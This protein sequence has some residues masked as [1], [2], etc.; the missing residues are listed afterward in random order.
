MRLLALDPST[1]CTGY[2][3]LAHVG[4]GTA[5]LDAGRLLPAKLAKPPLERM[6]D[7][8]DEISAIFRE[9]EPITAAVIETAPGSP[10]LRR[11]RGHT[12]LLTYATGVGMMLREVQVRLGRGATFNVSAGTWARKSKAHRQRVV[13][14]SFP[15]YDAAADPGMD[16]SDAIALGLWFIAEQ[17]AQEVRRG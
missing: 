17:A 12:N 9:H 13:A 4:A 14:M 16:V 6:A 2:A 11:R 15:A 3:V 8:C 5:L 7:M 1:R 10:F